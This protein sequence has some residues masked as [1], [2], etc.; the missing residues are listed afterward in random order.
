MEQLVTI[1]NLE[2]QLVQV[3]EKVRESASFEERVNALVAEVDEQKTKLNQSET[4]R[5]EVQRYA[6][7][8]LNK[9]KKDSEALEF[10]VDRR[11]IN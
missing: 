9:V 6:H 8:L 7:E 2:M 5:L 1:Q 4:E 10:M 11:L 3:K